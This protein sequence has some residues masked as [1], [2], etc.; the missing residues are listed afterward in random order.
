MWEKLRPVETIDF[1]HSFVVPEVLVKGNLK[2]N[3]YTR[4]PRT[5]EELK[6]AIRNQFEQSEEEIPRKV[7][8]KDFRELLQSYVFENLTRNSLH[9]G[10]IK[11]HYFSFTLM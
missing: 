5:L 11:F 9:I 2:A 6:S 1:L 8:A 10:V 3:V 4:N 7:S